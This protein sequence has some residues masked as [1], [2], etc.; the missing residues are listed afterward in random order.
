MSQF[1]KLGNITKKDFSDKNKTVWSQFKK[2]GQFEEN[3]N[4]TI[5][6]V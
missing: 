3:P 1:K 2:L 5:K 6:K 4:V